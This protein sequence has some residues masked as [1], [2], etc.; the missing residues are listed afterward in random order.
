MKVRDLKF[1]DKFRFK[2]DVDEKIDRLYIYLGVE[3]SKL[4]LGCY[5]AKKVLITSTTLL[6]HVCLTEEQPHTDKKTYIERQRAW[7]EEVGLKV[8]DTVKILRKAEADENGWNNNWASNMDAYV[9]KEVKVMQLYPDADYGIGLGPWDYPY[10]VLEK[11]ETKY[12]P[13]TYEDRDKFM[14]KIIDHKTD[15]YS[16]YLS[17][18]TSANIN[19]YT[20]QYLLDNFVWADGPDKGKPVGVQS[21]R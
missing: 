13:F 1:G 5:T 14:G 19:G 12:K 20:Y 7:V 8:G 17:A 3:D 11:V 10:F 18:C 15:G 9:G 21:R 16:L 6:D 2:G 4:S